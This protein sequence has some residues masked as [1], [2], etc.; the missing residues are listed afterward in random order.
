MAN[1]LESFAIR[2]AV[3]SS[4]VAGTINLII[5]YFVLKGKVEVPLFAA[6]AEIWNHS[7]IGALIPRSLVVSFLVTIVTVAATVKRASKDNA[8]TLK[9]IPWVKIALRKALIRALVAFL[10]VIGLALVLRSLFPAYATLPVSIV[11]PT[12]AI[13]AA[14]VA[15]SMTYSAVFSTG[16]TLESQN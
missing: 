4:L 13:F 9:T 14:L 2:R 8:E 15:F 16:K 12:V 3:L 5:V 1:T 6:V 7:L 10:L 11:I